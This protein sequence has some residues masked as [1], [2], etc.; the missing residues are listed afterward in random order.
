[1]LIRVMIFAVGIALAP[2]ALAVDNQPTSAQNGRNAENASPP[3]AINVDCNACAHADQ[4]KDQPQGWQRFVKWPEGIVTWAIV[5][6]LI[7]II[8]QSWETRRATT[9]QRD[10]DRARLFV[11]LSDDPRHANF[12]HLLN[13]AGL[14][15][16]YWSLGIRITQ[17]G[18]TK[19]FNV[20]GS[21]MIVVRPSQEKRPTQ[22]PQKMLRMYGIPS[23]V[24][25]ASS[26]IES[27]IEFRAIDDATLRRIAAEDDCAHFF[28]LIQ[29][30]D[31]FGASHKSTFRYVWRPEIREPVPGVEGETFVTEEAGWEIRGKPKDNHAT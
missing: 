25:E 12:D 27:L 23:V 20:F 31:V 8:W 30:Q 14:H 21:A 28:G 10:K 17:H 9:S 13:S 3:P 26:P 29:Y 15:D 24:S 18:S 6:T 16:F 1:M 11:E 22:S 5:F 19:A 4:G 7:A 2:I